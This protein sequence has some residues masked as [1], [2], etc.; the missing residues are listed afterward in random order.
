M[1][2]LAVIE[3]KTVTK[4][5][6]LSD[7]LLKLD[8]VELLMS[9]PMCPGKFVLIIGG[10]TASVENA[11][12]FA[13]EHMREHL[14]DI[15]KFGKISEQVYTAIIGATAVSN[16]DAVGIIE[17]FSIS[18]LIEAADI[19]VKATS[20]EIVE[21]RIARGMGGKSF[22]LLTGTTSDV[23]M[24]VESGKAKAK[25]AGLLVDTD[26]IASPHPELWQYIE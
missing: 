4:G 24:A 25:E 23:T 20:V 22:V 14:I 26:V 13:E 12:Q 17:T 9:Q 16:R 3:V 21:L 18:S 2:S 10:S 11:C 19:A 6:V 1:R 5:Y 7:D 15:S 8:N